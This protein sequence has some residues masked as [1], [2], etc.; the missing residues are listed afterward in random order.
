MAREE[1]RPP[2][3]QVDSDQESSDRQGQDLG[4]FSSSGIRSDQPRVSRRLRY[5]AK[6]QA[7]VL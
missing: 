2:H 3:Q 7:H 4:S 6:L 1:A 5:I